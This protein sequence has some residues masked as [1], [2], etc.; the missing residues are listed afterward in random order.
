[1][2][3]KSILT[4][5]RRAGGAIARRTRLQAYYDGKSDILRRA[6]ADMSKPTTASSVASRR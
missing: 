5:I 3:E 4:Y 6:M 2:T 1:M